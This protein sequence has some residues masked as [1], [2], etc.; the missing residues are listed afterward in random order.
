MNFHNVHF[1]SFKDDE[2]KIQRECEKLF[3]PERFDLHDLTTSISTLEAANPDLGALFYAQFKEAA[4]ISS[5]SDVQKRVILE[6]PKSGEIYQP[7]QRKFGE[8]HAQTSKKYGRS[9][10]QQQPGVH[11]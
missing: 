4:A 5:D 2:E 8:L 10:S 1:F 6:D 7:P 9:M 3:H 11:G